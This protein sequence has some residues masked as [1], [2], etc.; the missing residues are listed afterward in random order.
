MCH[1]EFASGKVKGR[2]IS[3][4]LHLSAVWIGVKK[5]SIIYTL[6]P[7]DKE[8]GSFPHKEKKKRDCKNTEKEQS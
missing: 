8:L 6:L 1:R 7:F 5:D 3:E 4:R 2:I